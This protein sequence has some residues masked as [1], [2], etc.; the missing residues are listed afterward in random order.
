MKSRINHLFIY[1]FFALLTFT[2]CQDETIDVNNPEE[3]EII[4]P[5]SQLSNFIG[6]VTANCGD[7]DNILDESSCFSIELPVTIIVGDVTIVI[8]TLD[9]LEE[10][11]DLFAQYENEDD[12]F[13]FVFPFTI[14]FNDYTQVVIENEEQLEDFIEDCEIEDDEVIECVDFVYPISFSVFNADFNI[15]DT[16]TISDDEALYNFLEALGGDDS[17]LIVSINYPVTLVYANGDT[18][19]VN[20]NQELSDAIEAAEADC[21]DD[22]DDCDINMQGLENLLLECGFEAQFYSESGDLTNS[23]QFQFS[24]S[25]LVTVTGDPTVVETGEWNIVETDLGYKLV[26][27][28]LET[29]GIANGLWL[30]TDCDDDNELEF[31]QETDNGIVTMK[32][33]LDCEGNLDCDAQ[34]IAL[35]LKEC[36]WW[37][38]TNLLS[39]NNNGPLNFHEGGTVTIGNNEEAI[40]TWEVLLGNTGVFLILD[41]SG[42]YEVLSRDWR[43]VVCEDDRLELVSDNDELVL[44]QGCETYNEV[45]DCFGNFELVECLGPNNEAEFNLSADTIGVIDCQ[46]AFVAT[47]HETQ[48]DAEA[49]I[50][51]IVE[52]ESY[53][54]TSGEVYLRIEAENG[55]FEVFTIFL[56][57]EECNYFECFESFDAILEQCDDGTDGP[58]YFDLTQAFSNCN[59]SADVVTYYETLVD[60]E[61]DVNAIS[62]P[63]TYAMLGVEAV[64]YTRVVIGDQYQIFPIILIVENCSS[65][66]SELDVDG[67]LVECIW[68]A[69]NYNGSDNLMNWNFDFEPNSQTVVIYNNETT[70][71]ATWTTSQSED[72]V[73]VTFSNV[74]GPN[75]Q[76]VTGEWLVVECEENR[77]QLQSGD[78]ILVLERTCE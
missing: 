60:A 70:I 58:Y 68:N 43:I 6:N 3:Q 45:F 13:D 16:V 63:E 61:T 42:D 32:L 73:I 39:P 14:M 9:D 20:S 11:E 78:N 62:N 28:G 44:E 36:Q 52:T 64:V 5:N 74:A 31:T 8:E 37:L 12:F 48:A 71:D 2:S 72:G 38:G 69:V 22:N 1:A 49:G 24:E 19:E 41:L 55:N 76:A 29:F 40:G 34:Q 7:Y 65:S 51:A 23:L 57:T 46:Y 56:N 66:C 21:D 27:E 10:L 53:W 75:I 4:Q 30:L 77:L 47:F 33:E 25:G 26:I 35:N 59:P 67:F 50:N 54:S 18:I 15:V 17:A